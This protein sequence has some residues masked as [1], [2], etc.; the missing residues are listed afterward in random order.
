MSSPPETPQVFDP[1][2][3][4]LGEG[5]LWHPLRGELFWFDI[6]GRRMLSRG[7]SANR[8]WS[9]DEMHSAAGWIDEEHLLVAS[10]TGL[11][12]FAIAT[13]ARDRICALEAENPVTRSNDGRA[14]PQGGFWIGTMGKNAEPGAGAIWRWYQGELRRLFAP[15]TISNAICFA[16]DGRSACFCDTPTRRVLRVALD[17]DGWPV[18]EPETHLDL[19][20]DG[21]NPDGAVIDA[22]GVLWVAQWGRARVAGYTPDGAFVEAY[23]VPAPHASCPAFGGPDFS[24]LYVTTALQGMDAEARA[25]APM[26]GA[27]FRVATNRQG[28]REHRVVVP[29]M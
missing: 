29:T 22:D 24:T 9:F 10:E 21:L 5:P 18:G 23:G 25:A 6:T 28:Q 12:R 26:A 14:D 19:T 15:I 20:R 2:P 3:C 16:P 27:T 4:D 17:A 8:S 13:G 11:W 7:E 1:R